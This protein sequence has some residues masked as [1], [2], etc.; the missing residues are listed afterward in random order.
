MEY[1][2]PF[3]LFDLDRIR[4]RFDRISSAFNGAVVYYA[5]KANNNREVLGEL[6]E[7]GSG[8]DIGSKHEAEQLLALGVEPEKMIF[9][10]PIKLQ[11]HIRDTFRMGV[12]L[13]VF[14]SE[15]E[16]LKLALLAPG[17]R[18]LV[19][20]AVGNS[21]SFF[22]LGVKFGTPPEEAV[23]L[24]LKAGAL[25]LRPHG[26]AF[27]V[28]SQCTRKETWREAMELS[29]AVARELA[30]AGLDCPALDIGGGFPI[31]YSEDV[32]SVEEI[33][34]EVL[35]V[36]AGRF[37]PGTEMLVEPG[38]YVVGES[39]ILATTVIGRARRGGEDWLFVDVSAFHGLL[40]AQQMNG[41]F[42]YPIRAS[43]NGTA[44]R[45]FVLSGPTCDPDDTI[46]AEVWLPDV[47]IGERLYIQNVG[48]YSFV[49]ATNFH[50]FS[51]PEIH[52]LSR[53]AS[54]DE[55][56]AG[57]TG[58]QPY[59]EFGE[60]KR[61]ETEHEGQVARTYF[62]I[63]VIPEHWREPL[64]RCYDE[65]MHSTE[66]IQEQSCYDRES[67]MEAMSDH[68]YG[69]VVLTVDGEPVGLLMGTNDLER[70]RAAYI[71]PSFIEKRFAREVAEGRFWYMTC[72]YISPKLRNLGFV[73]QMFTA[74]T[75]GIKEK[76]WVFGG[77][78]T[79]SKLFVLDIIEKVSAEEGY[80][81]KSRLLGTQ[82]Y[83]A[84]TGVLDEERDGAATGEL[85]S[86]GKS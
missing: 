41:R 24:M 67:F 32:P 10:A 6:A 70:A 85:I 68:G 39:A 84:F 48:A 54:L 21:G 46:M 40:E 3:F 33:A 59:S 56:G 8:F 64:W 51:P 42:P 27:H 9:S 36:F 63:K 7:A 49:Y 16:L 76:R 55:F 72:W 69:K 47:K 17:S 77:D 61:Y 11:S 62:Y 79:D 30:A 19:R 73:R 37:P 60:E 23:S 82:S 74:V 31:K 34:S 29:A 80:P 75:H 2:T 28:G 43:H 65:S 52:L 44:N 5:V 45:K 86:Q 18:V 50:G 15:E 4:A 20:L 1:E 57:E 66:A 14:D 26:I 25:G 78:I 71:N 83:F 53:G 58:A 38:R 81:I 13:F 35:E 22:P 12:D